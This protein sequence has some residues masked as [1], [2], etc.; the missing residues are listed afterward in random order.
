[1]ITKKEAIALGKAIVAARD[2]E[3]LFN[4][5]SFNASDAKVRYH[6]NGVC[7]YALDN[8]WYDVLPNKVKEQFGWSVEAFKDLVW[9]QSAVRS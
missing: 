8:L 7:G 5:V 9:P 4:E 1:M 2:R 6:A 3:V